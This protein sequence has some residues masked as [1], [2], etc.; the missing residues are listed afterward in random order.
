[1]TFWGSLLK[2]SSLVIYISHLVYLTWVVQYPST[3]MPLCKKVFEWSRSHLHLCEIAIFFC[4]AILWDKQKATAQWKPASGLYHLLCN[5]LPDSKISLLSK[6]SPLKR[7]II[8][9]R[10][11]FHYL[12]ERKQVHAWMH[13]RGSLLW[14]KKKWR[15]NPICTRDK[16]FER[17][18]KESLN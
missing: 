13:T 11:I 10:R 3:W 7:Q 17:L 18:F 6:Q 1:M 12:F 8:T 16:S 4:E 15:I 14:R 9:H 5:C 2:F